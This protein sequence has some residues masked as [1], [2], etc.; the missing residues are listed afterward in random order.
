MRGSNVDYHTQK[1]EKRITK[2][3]ESMKQDYVSHRCYNAQDL[4]L[5]KKRFSRYA[6]IVHQQNNRHCSE[7]IRSIL[8]LLDFDPVLKE[9][10]SSIV[11]SNTS[12]R[13]PVVA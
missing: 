9:G 3:I 7:K 6:F 1:Q 2:L 12:S 4:E 8:D 5:L 13:H 11:A 10:L